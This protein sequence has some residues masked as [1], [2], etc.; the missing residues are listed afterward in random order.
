MPREMPAVSMI[1]CFHQPPNPLVRDLLPQSFAMR[2][3]IGLTFWN[4][5]CWINDRQE[6]PYPDL[7]GLPVLSSACVDCCDKQRTVHPTSFKL[8]IIQNYNPVRCARI[9]M[10]NIAYVNRSLISSGSLRKICLQCQYF[11]YVLISAYAKKTSEYSE[12]CPVFFF[13]YL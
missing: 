8:Y 5:P 10:I 7:S 4:L 1:T 13:I 3:V 2:F 6:Y 11:S 12:Q 9:R